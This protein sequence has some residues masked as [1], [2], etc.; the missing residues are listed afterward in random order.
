MN[1]RHIYIYNNEI[2]PLFRQLTESGIHSCSELNDSLDSFLKKEHLIA[3]LK[4]QSHDLAGFLE[5]KTI[6]LQEVTQQVLLRTYVELYV[7][8]IAY[9]M[10]THCS[11]QELLGLIS[12]S[13]EPYNKELHYSGDIFK[14]EVLKYHLISYLNDYFLQTHRNPLTNKIDKIVETRPTIF[15]DV[16]RHNSPSGIE[17]K[18]TELQPSDT[19]KPVITC[20]YEPYLEPY[21]C[22]YYKDFRYIATAI[23]LLGWNLGQAPITLCG[24]S[25]SKLYVF[26]E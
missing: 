9:S 15:I 8:S 23:K 7:N 19:S 6:N 18:F 22:R 14:P 2:R 4:E 24:S 17:A 12:H 20:N 13:T 26:K 3:Y 10:C 1:D 25:L 16:S 5:I 11:G 21:I